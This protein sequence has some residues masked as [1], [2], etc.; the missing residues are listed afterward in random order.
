MNKTGKNYVKNIKNS[1]LFFLLLFIVVSCQKKN[2]TK[3]PV[4]R[5]YQKTLY[6]EEIPKDIYTKQSKED[7]LRALRDYIEK[8][9][10]EQLFVEEAKKNVDT[11][12]INRLVQ[13]YQN[14]LLREKYL[15]K[16]TNKY[17][18][19]TV[20]LDTL[21]A[22][23]QQLKSIFT[24]REVLV[25]PSILILPKNS[26]KK[27]TY[28]KWFFDQKIEHQDSLFKHMG[29]FNKMD[30]TGQKWYPLSKLYEEFP[31]LKRMSKRQIIKKRKKIITSDSL[32]L[33]LMFIKDVVNKDEPLPLKFIE[34][35]IKQLILSKRKQEIEKRIIN[36]IKEE[37]I[38]NK[39]FVIYSVTKK[40]KKE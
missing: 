18:D 39:H 23:Y 12:K 19:T 36:E 40:S 31:V 34:K 1:F 4:A 28:Q 32:S 20:S 22:H 29:E 3:I 38:K 25:Q 8:W 5:I 15:N 27:Y 13:R 9:A 21:Q 7:S 26:K 37:A 2:D 30:L 10:N 17:L 24:A 14:D 11:G 6:L 33:Y 35:D 16:L